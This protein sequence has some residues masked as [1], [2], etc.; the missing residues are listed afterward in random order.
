MGKTDSLGNKP[1]CLNCRYCPCEWLM[2]QVKEH[3]CPS[4]AFSGAC[5]KWEE[6]LRQEYPSVL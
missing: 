3:E 5:E 1:I 6:R 4:M 2:E